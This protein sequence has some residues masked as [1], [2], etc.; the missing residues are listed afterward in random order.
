MSATSLHTFYWATTI[1]SCFDARPPSP[2]ACQLAITTRDIIHLDDLLQALGLYAA[3]YE[4]PFNVQCTAW[5]RDFIFRR[6][7]PM[8]GHSGLAILLQITNIQPLP[9][10]DP[11]DNDDVAMLQTTG[12]PEVGSKATVLTLED[13]VPPDPKVVV[14]FTKAAEAYLNIMHLHFDFM[15][16]WPSDLELPEETTQAIASLHEHVDSPAVAYHFYVDGSKVAGHGV[17]A[18][19]ACLVETEQGLALAG[20]IP[21]HVDFATHAYIG[22]HAAMLHALLWAIQLSTWHLTHFPYH[23]LRISFNFDALN[24][25]Y[26]AAGWWRAHEHTEWQ[27]I[28]RSLAHILEHRHGSRH[29]D[30]HH[31]RAHAQHPWNELVDRVAKYASMHPTRVGNCQQWQHWLSDVTFLMAIQWIGYLEAMRAQHPHVATLHGLLLE[32]PLRLPAHHEEGNADTMG[33][34]VTA[35]MDIK[36]DV[37]FA[38]ANVLTLTTHA[39]AHTTSIT[40]QQILMKQFHD[41]GCHVVGLQ[42]TRHRHLRDLSN[43][44]YHIVGSPATA[45]GHDGV[46][47]WIS[48]TLAFY[49]NGP[50]ARKQN[51]LVVAA[52]SAFLIV[53]IKLQHWRCLLVTARA[54][55]SGHGLHQIEQFWATISKHIRQLSRTWPVIFVG[56]TNGHLGEQA[57]PAVGQHYPS[58]E[59]T[60]GTAFHHW[61]LEQ[62]LFVPATFPQHCDGE[63]VHTFVSPD[64]D[65]TSRI[66]YIALPM[67]LQYDQVKTWV[68]EDIDITTQ[69]IDH[70][71]VI[72]HM[73]LTKQITS[74]SGK[75]RPTSSRNIGSHVRHVLQDPTTLHDLRE[76]I[77]MPPW[78]TDPHCTADH[79]T[80]Q[81]QHA[82][83][84]LVP[85]PQ[86]QPRKTHISDAT[87]QLVDAQKALFRQLRHMKKA[88]NHTIIKAIFQAWSGKDPS[89]RLQGWLPLCDRAVATTMSSLRATTQKVTQAIRAE[90]A[91]YYTALAQRAAHTYSVEGLTALWKH[92]KA[93]L[94]K[95]R[96]R[97]S[98]QKFDML[99]YLA[100]SKHLKLAPPAHLRKF[101][102]DV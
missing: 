94:P 77:Q 1:V 50:A 97:H 46:Q 68:A 36:I 87:W 60:S 58:R 44:H 52:S 84:Q 31:I 41:A 12:K 47:L 37:T 81:T 96:M 26:Q 24:T 90:D 29:I 2:E 69:R 43:P 82:V 92:I 85:A 33:D 15:T 6:H 91:A 95:N 54:P 57:T 76:A 45:A 39:E 73:T 35:F 42:E 66:D 49:T 71:P 64:G 80:W 98:V 14:D 13:L 3:C 20:V 83:H 75:K 102:T 72:C 28:F 70:L 56:D 10:Q 86:R 61:L 51:I 101:T 99:T 18:A 9:A 78:A 30:W 7:V 22:E 53:K 74:T 21:A 25:G 38:T 48:K 19:T 34:P 4:P 63:T 62:R 32:H 55:H 23:P 59:N 40:R 67:Q 93:V 27:T 16:A 79:L 17:G 65:R 8:P 100:T 89:A 88:Y 11:P 5:H